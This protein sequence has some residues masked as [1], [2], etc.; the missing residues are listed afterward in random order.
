MKAKRFKLV[1]AVGVLAIISETVLWRMND[2]YGRF[3]D[4]G[5]ALGVG[6]FLF[7]FPG[8]LIADLFGLKSP[9]DNAVATPII[10]TCGG[11]QFFLIYW[12]TVA[13]LL[14]FAPKHSTDASPNGG[15]TQQVGTSG[16]S[17]GPPSV[18]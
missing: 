15:P 9:Q 7:H 10:V 4:N 13:A 16:V 3:I 14:H 18:S 11:V 2:S 1:V 17:G 5:N 6:T 8:M 12:G